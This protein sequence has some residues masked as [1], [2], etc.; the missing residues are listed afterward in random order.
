MCTSTSTDTTRNTIETKEVLVEV[1]DD[2][3]GALYFNRSGQ[4][5]ASPSYEKD[6]NDTNP[7]ERDILWWIDAV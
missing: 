2:D 3:G 6:C 7:R 5:F 1:V 4:D